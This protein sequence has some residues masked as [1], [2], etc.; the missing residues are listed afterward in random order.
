M[1][2]TIATPAECRKWALENGHEVG[3]RGRLSA[4]IVKAFEAA[5]GSVVKKKDE[6]EA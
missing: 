3:A 4:D 2:E 6:D 5:T 1:A